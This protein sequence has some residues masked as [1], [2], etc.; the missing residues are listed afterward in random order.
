[1]KKNYT[2]DYIFKKISTL[3]IEHLKAKGKLQTGE[4]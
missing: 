1:M 4:K 3:F 2:F